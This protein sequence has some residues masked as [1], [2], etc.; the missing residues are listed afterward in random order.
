MNTKKIFLKYVLFNILSMIGISCYVL[1]D[2]LFISNGVGLDGLTALNLTLPVYNLIFG[3]GALIGV[4]G[5]T[6][7]SILRAQGKEY[8][9]SAYFTYSF[10]MTMIV[11]IPFIIIGGV[12]PEIVV[13]MLGANYEV[14]DIAAIYLRTFIIF[15]PFF[16]FEHV[17]VT[18]IRND[19]NPRLASLAMLCATLFNIL[20]DYILVYPC[21]LGMFGAAL[22]T[23]ASPIIALSI[24]SLHFFKKQNHFHFVKCYFQWEYIKNIIQIGFP[25]FVTELSSGIIVFV[26]NIVVFN[27][28]GNTAVASYGIISNL[29]I[30]VTSFYNGI[31]Q[32]IQPLI[33]QSYAKLNYQNMKSYL[34]YAY[35]TSLIISL[36]IYVCVIIFPDSI[37]AIFNSESNLVMAKIAKEGLFLYFAG[38]FFVGLNMITTSY[39]ASIE[40]MKPS[41]TLS[42][43][44]GGIVIIPLVVILAQIL[45][46]HGVWLSFPISELC[47]FIFALFLKHKEVSYE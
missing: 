10:W 13:K 44:R 15:T 17:V 41:S 11:S 9:A 18:F 43:L 29:A 23:G 47:V 34:R 4:G 31:A 32:G 42:L 39:F 20:F 6:R 2:T 24:C 7:F 30:V 22:A 21:Q 1:A 38:F 37:V 3:L 12:F 40:K 8:D 27:I 46:I 25:S 14:I 45:G 36:F 28:G 5:A 16:I 26:F 33:S 35:I 19:H